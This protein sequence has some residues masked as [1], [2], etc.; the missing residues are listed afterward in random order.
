[1]AF[2]PRYRPPPPPYT[3]AMETTAWGRSPHSVSPEV[4]GLMLQFSGGLH[5]PRIRPLHP[6]QEPRAERGRR[7]TRHLWPIARIKG[8]Q[9]QEYKLVHQCS[10]NTEHT[11]T[12]LTPNASDRP[13]H[14]ETHPKGH[15]IRLRIRWAPEWPRD[16]S[17]RPAPPGR[18]TPDGRIISAM[19]AWTPPLAARRERRPRQGHACERAR[20]GAQTMHA[21]RS[22]VWQ[23]AERVV[24]HGKFHAC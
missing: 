20:G 10:T 9:C 22:E 18:E 4:S 21:T 17:A 3:K 15:P 23:M 11:N 2:N 13:E 16:A 8:R 6:D 19:L 1:M 24:L 5:K 12:H 7:K 14:V